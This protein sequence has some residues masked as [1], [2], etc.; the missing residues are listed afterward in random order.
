MNELYQVLGVWAEAA[1][2]DIKAAFRNLAKQL[3][4]DVHP[5][6]TDARATVPRCCSRL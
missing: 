3:H 5:G 1:D 2:E 4:P 6:D